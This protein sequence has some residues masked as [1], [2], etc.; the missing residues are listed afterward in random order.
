MRQNKSIKKN[1]IYNLIYQVYILIIPIL[2]TPY[3]S[4]ILLSDGI[5]KYSFTNSIVSYFNLIAALGFGIYAQRLIA[6]DSH[7]KHKQSIDFWEII[8]SRLFS[9][10]I[11]FIAYTIVIL[12]NVC[13]QKYSVLLWVQSMQ[14]IAVIF[15]I[16]FLLQG[17]EEFGKIALRNFIIKSI[18]IILI[19]ALIKKESDVTK[20]V[21]IQ[22]ATI[23]ISNMSLWVYCKK[24]L[25]K[26]KIEELHPF[27]HIKPTFLLF[28]PTIAVSIYTTLDKTL[29]G[30]ITKN[31]S[32]VGNY[33]NGEKLVKLSITIISSLITVF[34][35]R[36]A[37]YYKDG[38]IDELKNN[39]SVLCKFVFLIGIPMTF[40]FIAIADN[41]IPWYLGKEYGIDNLNNVILIIKILSPIIIIIGLGS[42][43]GGALLI[44]I[45][46]DS[47]YTLAVSIGAIINF[48][49]NFL[50][51]KYYGSV[52][53]AISTVIA[54]SFVT[55]FMIY[56]SRKY[57]DF[58]GVLKDLCKQLFAGIVM[59]IICYLVGKR[60]DSSMINTFIIVV[61]GVVI[62]FSLILLFRESLIMEGLKEIKKKINTK[63]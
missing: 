21:F 5:G 49:L 38:K 19:F 13:G 61:I 45:Q 55:I 4:R 43:L 18:S 37:T 33:D 1:Y 59:F 54:E 31:D 28:I 6:R 25:D 57:L 30:F 62:Y 8:I 60:F 7:D 12:T 15:D 47:R 11:S 41:L 58:S 53:A 39:I 42:V 23:L 32:L 63:K 17:N 10:A 29:I 3:V 2:V 35:P 14:I 56:F 46:K 9:S 52:G 26:V 50:F 40:G 51:I 20:Y 22:A 27:R 34:I 16:T 44:P 24:M 36:N 48:S